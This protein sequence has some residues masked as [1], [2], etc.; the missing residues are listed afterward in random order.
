[1]KRIMIIALML[2]LIG[3]NP[4]FAGSFHHNTNNEGGN[5]RAEAL[6]VGVGVGIS[7][8]KNTNENTVVGVN[9]NF[10]A[11]LNK[12]DIDVNNKVKNTVKVNNDLSNRVNTTDINLNKN[13]QD[14]KQAQLQAQ[15]AN[16]KQGQAQDASNKQGQ[17]T[18]VILTDNS[19]TEDNSVY[20]A[21][22]ATTP[23]AGTASMQIT[24]PFG[25]AGFSKDA[26]YSIYKYKMDVTEEA[27]SRGY[28]TEEER[29][30]MGAYL[31][32]KFIRANKKGV[33]AHIVDP[34][35]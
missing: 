35:F 18:D 4:V 7:A 11:N 33:L 17:T 28:I 2:G 12:N 22:P 29:V 16:N 19:T 34:L 30:K 25:G 32:K 21:P 6:A 13:E 15:S 1:M 24:S 23:L 9:K 26:Q 27:F 31:Y 8:N 3:C 20:L 14:Q 5:S 10:N